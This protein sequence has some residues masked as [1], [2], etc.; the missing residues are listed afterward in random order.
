LYPSVGGLCDDN[1]VDDVDVVADDEDD[2]DAL[3]LALLDC[4]VCPLLLWLDRVDMGW[5]GV[6]E[7]EN[8]P[9]VNEPLLLVDCC[10]DDVDDIAVVVTDVPPK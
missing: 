6:T 2:D 4:T 5:G 7:T 9:L 10:D 3:V 8:D 1:G